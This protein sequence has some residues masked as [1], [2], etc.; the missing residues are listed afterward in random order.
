MSFNHKEIEKK[1]QNIGKK[2]K[3]LK[4]SEDNE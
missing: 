3:H 4:L 1:W 2:I